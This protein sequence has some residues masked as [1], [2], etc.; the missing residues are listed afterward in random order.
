VYNLKSFQVEDLDVATEF[1]RSHNFVTIVTHGP[2]GLD[3]SHLPVIV[4][5]TGNALPVLD[6]HLARANRQWEQFDGA[7]EALAIFQGPHG[8]VS[9][10]LYETHPSVPTWNYQVVH[11]TGI[12]TLIDDPADVR[13]HVLEL[14]ERHEAG[15]PDRWT[16]NLPEDVFQS[17]LQQ[18]VAVR[19]EL[20]RVETKFKVGQNRPIADRENMALAFE[21]DNNSIVRDLGAA[22]RRT[23]DG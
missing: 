7:T 3:A 9:P 18:I 22:I 12:P 11:A 1:M 8:Y 20:T 13:E 17:L 10:R 2:D 16:P 21:A 15:S 14:V 6:A 19:M 23:L 5:R 4:S